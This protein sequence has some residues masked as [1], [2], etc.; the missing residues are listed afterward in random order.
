MAVIWQT[1]IVF[2]V[3]VGWAKSPAVIGLKIGECL[4]CEVALDNGRSMIMGFT[5]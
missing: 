4:T 5:M 1:G 3:S 2:T